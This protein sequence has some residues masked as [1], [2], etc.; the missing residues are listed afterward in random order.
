MSTSRRANSLNILILIA[1]S[2]Y[3][4]GCFPSIHKFHDQSHTLLLLDL[5]FH[6]PA[7]GYLSLPA[8]I[9]KDLAHTPTI[10]GIQSYKKIIFDFP[11]I[12]LAWWNMCIDMFLERFWL[13]AISVVK[14]AGT[15]LDLWYISI[16]LMIIDNYALATDCPAG[17]RIRQLNKGWLLLPSNT[18]VTA[19]HSW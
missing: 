3:F 8:V 15:C 14:H 2:L 4:C 11:V 9:I 1:V 6:L 18:P 17:V 13:Q 19:H 10:L 5:T 12:S 7:E 16:F